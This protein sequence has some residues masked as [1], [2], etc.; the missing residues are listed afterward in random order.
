LSIPNVTW[1]WRSDGGLLD[2]QK[3]MDGADQ[4][5]MVITAPHYAGKVE[6][7]K[8]PDDQ[9]NAEFEERLLHDPRFQ[10]PFLFQM[11]RFAPVE[12]AIFMNKSLPCP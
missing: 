3:V 8:D 11:G 5:E 1:L 4:S 6:D 9:Y 10:G 2:W 7:K 12:V